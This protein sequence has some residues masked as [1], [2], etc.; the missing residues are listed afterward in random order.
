MVKIRK[1]TEKDYDSLREIYFTSREKNFTWSDK[2]RFKIEDFDNDTKDEFILVATK[3]EQILG[4]ISLWVPDNFIHHLYVHPDFMGQQAGKGLLQ[5]SI[6]KFG[7]PLTLKC[8][9]ENTKALTFYKSQGWQVKEEAMGP[10]GPYCLM[11]YR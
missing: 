3:N 4:F 10:D 5:A 1:A 2:S 7:M 11:E 9:T 8:I 6:E